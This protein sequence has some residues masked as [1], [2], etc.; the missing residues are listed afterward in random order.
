MAPICSFVSSPGA[1]VRID[2]GLPEN[3]LRERKANA[4]DVGERSFDALLVGDIDA[5]ESCHGSWVLGLVALTLFVARVF[6]DD[7]NHSFAADDAAG[8]AEFFYGWTYF[9][10]DGIRIVIV[11]NRNQP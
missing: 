9:H 11:L 3:F 10:G 2:V 1:G 7:A 8:F 4:V 5:E 6:A